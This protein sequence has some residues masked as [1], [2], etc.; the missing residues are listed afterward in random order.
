MADGRTI[1][2]SHGCRKYGNTLS[3]PLLWP[4]AIELRELP[5]PRPSE[6]RQGIQR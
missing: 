2:P 1:C 6:P 5:E 3:S 4:D